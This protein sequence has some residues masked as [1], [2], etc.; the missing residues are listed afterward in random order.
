MIN[1]EVASASEKDG[2]QLLEF[3]KH[4]NVKE[5]INNRVACYLSPNF[6][7]IAK[8]TDTVVGLLQWHVKENPR[9]ALTEFEEVFVLESY[10]RKGIGTLLLEYAIQSARDYL[11]ISGE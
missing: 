9:L 11:F 8:Y 2:K 3:F 6:S 7:V 5:I 1:V 4:Y 10:R